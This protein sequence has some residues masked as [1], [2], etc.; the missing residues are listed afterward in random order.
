MFP[1]TWALV[2]HFSLKESFL[3]CGLHSVEELKI[4]RIF[5]DM[6]VMFSG[7]VWRSLS[8]HAG[9]V[10]WKSVKKSFLTCGLCSM[11]EFGEVFLD[12]WVVFNGRVWRSLSWHVGCVTTKS[13]KKSLLTSGLHPERV[14]RGPSRHVEFEEAFLV[15]RKEFEEIYFSKCAAL[16]KIV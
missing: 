9:H 7:R 13:S 15:L 12:T 6:Q 11:E 2:W 5:L 10:Q 16:R 1:D 8:W 14:S 4:K 3:T